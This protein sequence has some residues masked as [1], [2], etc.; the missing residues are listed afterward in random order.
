MVTQVRGRPRPA[1]FPGMAGSVEQPHS[2]EAAGRNRA[3]E[4]ELGAARRNVGSLQ[5]QVVR[6][7]RELADSRRGSTALRGE[8]DASDQDG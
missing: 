7:E 1:I 8:K 6:L 5:A 2:A 3:L 4:E